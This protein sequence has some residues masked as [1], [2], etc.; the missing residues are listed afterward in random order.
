MQ[1][2]ESYLGSI[3]NQTFWGWGVHFQ[4]ASE[5]TFMRSTE[6]EIRRLVTRPCYSPGK[7][8]S[9]TESTRTLAVRTGRGVVELEVSGI[10]RTESVMRRDSEKGGRE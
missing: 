4:E 9:W 3:L 7:S 5:V 6:Q 1:M 2:P 8:E 10:H